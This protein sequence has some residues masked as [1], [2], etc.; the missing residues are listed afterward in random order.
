MVVNCSFSKNAKGTQISTES[1]SENHATLTS[2]SRKRSKQNDHT[3]KTEN[4]RFHR[5]LSDSSLS[6]LGFSPLCVLTACSFFRQHKFLPSSPNDNQEEKC[7][8]SPDPREECLYGGQ[9]E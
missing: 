7:L 4:P 1:P 6:S 9:A 3:P 5:S 8:L 2:T